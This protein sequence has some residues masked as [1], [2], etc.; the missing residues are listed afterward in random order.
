MTIPFQN[1]RYDVRF[2]VTPSEVKA[3]QAL[4]YR[5]FFG[6]EGLDHDRFDAQCKQLMVTDMTGRLVATVRLFEMA[7]G[8]DVRR[9]YAAQC[10]DLK[11]FSAVSVP[12]IEIGRFCIRDDVVDVDVLRV[13]WAALTGRVDA[14]G[15]AFIYGCT[16]FQGTDPAPFGRSFARLHMKHLGPDDLRPGQIARTA[17]R[18]A[19]LP[20]AGNDPMP[21]LL[22]TYLA[23]GGWVSDHAVIDHAMNRLHVFTCLE[24]AKVPAARARALR[25]LA[26]T[27]PLA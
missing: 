14:L 8:S 23:M 12:L 1:T 9:S 13:A 21:P 4:R 2:A 7:D 17:F 3:C 26:K 16:S 5:C 24:V 20:D 19:D 27:C 15:A 18:L 25:A 10:Y 22:R 11:G 6:G